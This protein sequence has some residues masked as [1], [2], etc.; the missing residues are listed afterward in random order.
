MEVLREAAD[1]PPPAESAPARPT[2]E[3]EVFV[4]RGAEIDALRS[5][6]RV[7]VVTGE[8]GSGKSSLLRRFPR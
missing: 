8:A 1:A 3:E 7:A 6:T 5:A 4:G 2:R